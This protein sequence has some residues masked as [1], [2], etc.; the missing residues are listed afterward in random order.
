MFGF[1]NA[2]Q[3]RINELVLENRIL[4]T[5]L[6][7]AEADLTKEKAAHSTSVDAHLREIGRTNRLAGRLANAHRALRDIK[8]M[9]TA[10]CAHIGRKMAARADEALPAD[11]GG[12]PKPDATAQFQPTNGAAVPAH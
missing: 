2:Q 4:E 11:M 12:H 8:G 1:K 3:K 10:H 9:A 5:A 6:A 7:S